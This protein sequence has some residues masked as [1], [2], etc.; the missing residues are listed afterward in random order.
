M[1]FRSVPVAVAAIILWIGASVAPGNIE[2]THHGFGGPGPEYQICQPC[3]TP[4]HADAS[5]QGAPLWNHEITSA[6]F[7]QYSSATMNATVGQPSGVTKLCLSC[8]DGTVAVD[9]FSGTSGTWYVGGWR[10]K[11]LIGTDLSRHH[12]VSFRYDP[13]LATADGGL[14]DPETTPSGLGGTISQDLL[15]QGRLECVACHDVH[16]SRATYCT[17]CHPGGGDYVETVS[18][19]KPNTRSALCLTCHKK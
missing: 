14:H 19:W 7:S 12:P 6:S 4:H 8:H 9:S 13:N 17:D 2:Y 3:H 5:A 10:G 1:R 15:R 11:G 18:L 16:V